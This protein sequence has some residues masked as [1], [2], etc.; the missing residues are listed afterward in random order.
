MRLPKMLLLPAAVLA[1]L[2]PGAVA[3]VCQSSNGC[4]FW[5]NNY[6]EYVLYEQDTT[7]VDVLIYPSAGP[8]PLRD[9]TIAKHSVQAWK[10]GINNY[11]QTWFKNSVSINAYA[12]GIDATPPPADAI[13]DPEVIIVISEH[14]PVLLFGIGLQ[15]PFSVCTQQGGVQSVA[16]PHVHDGG[17][18]QQVQ[19]RSGGF[20]CLALNT[21]FLLGGTVQMFDLI[22][23][24]FGH[25]LGTGHVGDA[26][27]F[28]A[29]TVPPYDVMSY[30]YTPSGKNCVSNLNIRTM[31]GVYAPLLS[32]PSSTWLQPGDY[33]TMAPSAYLP[34][35]APCGAL[36]VPLTG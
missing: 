12:P 26:L 25:C 18:V 35:S 11:G 3:E 28:N 17:F 8:F 7:K 9:V 2:V 20:V 21:N 29:K 33:Y 32:Q 34:T 5:D 13:T 15:S 24:E 36:F 23:H 30:Q 27:D 22:A 19:C 4:Q 14:D 1:F 16:E 6:H 10:D 31:E